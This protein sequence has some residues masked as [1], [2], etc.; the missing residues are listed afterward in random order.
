MATVVGWRSDISNEPGKRIERAI[1]LFERE[2]NT[3]TRYL[4]SA[5]F[6]P[7]ESPLFSSRRCCIHKNVSY[8]LKRYSFTLTRFNF[9]LS[10]Y[11]EIFQIFFILRPFWFSEWKERF[12]TGEKK[13]IFYY[14]RFTS[15]LAW[16]DPTRINKYSYRRIHLFVSN[17]YR[18]H[19]LITCCGSTYNWNLTWNSLSLFIVFS[20][21]FSNIKILLI[22]IQ[23]HRKILDL[24]VENQYSWSITIFSSFKSGSWKRS[25]SRSLNFNI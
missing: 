12:E 14:I 17:D 13:E 22:R 2:R 16:H 4:D 1:F 10:H 9:F 25:P 11:R 8:V 21:L 15:Y 3:G 19:F 20:F 18:I 23:K 7:E 6:C 24:I 5:S